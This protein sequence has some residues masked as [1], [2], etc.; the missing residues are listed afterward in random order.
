MI[1]NGPLAFVTK[2]DIDRL[3]TNQVPESVTLDYKRELKLSGRDDKKEFLADVTAFNN[4]QGGLLIF[5]IQEEKDEGNKNTGL[6]DKVL[7][8]TGYNEDQLTLQ[9]ESILRD[10]TQP[11]LTTVELGFVPYD[12]GIVLLLRVPPNYGTPRMVTFGKTNKFHRRTAGGKYLPDVYEL[13]EMFMQSVAQREKAV[14]FHRKRLKMMRKGK[15]LSLPMGKSVV[16]HLVPIGGDRYNQLDLS[17]ADNLIA[18]KQVIDSISVAGLAKSLNIDGYI[19]TTNLNYS[20]GQRDNYVTE[21]VQ[22]FRNGGLEMFTT[23]PFFYESHHEGITFQFGY[24]KERIARAIAQIEVVKSLLGVNPPFIIKVAIMGVKDVPLRFDQNP[25][26]FNFD[27][28]VLDVPSVLVVDGEEDR[29]VAEVLS[30]IAQA[31]GVN[32]S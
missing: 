28:N 15:L 23:H 31:A 20:T 11:A 1:F 12:N 2:A 7:P 18:L 30:I 27:R 9:V 16:F 25:R 6:P 5:G 8:L 14:S 29:A 26:R 24:L 17:G 13:E 3:I 22:Y 4:T 32:L 21:Y 10:G 19:G